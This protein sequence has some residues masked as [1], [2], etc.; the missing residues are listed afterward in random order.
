[1]RVVGLR[2]L[3]VVAGLAGVSALAA[4]AACASD[5]PADTSS[6]DAGTDTLKFGDAMPEAEAGVPIGNVCG[7]AKGLEKD[8]PWPMRG[9]CPK[10]AGVSA[11]GGPAAATVK[12]AVALPV[13]ESSPAVSADHHVWIG[14]ADGDVIALSGGGSVV[15]AFH[16][17]GA[18]RSSPARASSGLTVIGGGDGMLYGLERAPDP[19]DGGVDGGD[20]G[21]DGGFPLH[22]AVWSHAVGPMSSS[23]AIGADGTIYVGT[24]AGKLVAVTGDGKT[25]KWSA[26][27]NDTGGGSPAIGGD[28][29]IYVGSADGKVYAVAPDGKP[30]WTYAT[31]GPITGSPAV[32]GGTLYVGSDDKKL[33]AIG[34][35]A[36][37]GTWTYATL[38]AVASP[39]IGSDQ[40]VYVGS[41]D[42]NLYAITPSGLLY[43]AVKAKGKI[44]SVPALG[45]DET[46]YVTTDTAILAIGR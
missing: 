43:F 26:T 23:P 10:R 11:N 22:R 27:T 1:M 32:Y 18:V 14:T 46:L 38:G 45:D 12:W 16:T 17:V 6:K 28:E 7:D 33:H 29:T 40:T 13:G 15:G 4:L 21:G 36:G 41:A 3:L 31:G 19:P 9:G 24:T 34:T 44:H 42:G 2:S 20:D 8:A 35:E 25:T 5:D 37:A 39:V 30:R